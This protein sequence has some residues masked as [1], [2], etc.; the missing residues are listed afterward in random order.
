MLNR[1]NAVAG[2]L[3]HAHSKEEM[4]GSNGVGPATAAK[5]KK[6]GIFNARDLRA[7]KPSCCD[8]SANWRGRHES[9]D[10]RCI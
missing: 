2:Y 8:I 4:V 1:A 5:M 7:T 10:I 6:L 9:H 3:F